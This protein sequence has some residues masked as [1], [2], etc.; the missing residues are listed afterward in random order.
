MQTPLDPSAKTFQVVNL[1]FLEK[2][3]AKLIGIQISILFN[4][5][6]RFDPPMFQGKEG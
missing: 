1:R 5:V 4:E 6:N 3:R 2:Q